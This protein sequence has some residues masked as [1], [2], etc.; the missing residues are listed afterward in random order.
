MIILQ[1][2]INAIDNIK[3]VEAI[4]V[5]LKN[6]YAIESRIMGMNGITSC[7]FFTCRN[8]LGKGIT[9][10]IQ[11]LNKLS[12]ENP[13]LHGIIYLHNDEDPIH[14]NIWQVWIIRKGIIEKSIDTFLSPISEK[15]ENY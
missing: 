8:H 2:W 13:D 1:G 3:K 6:D 9:E 11:K 12:K 15:T 14:S 4:R 10:L 5:E 7:S